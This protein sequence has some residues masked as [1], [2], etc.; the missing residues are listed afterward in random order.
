M[1]Q[2]IVPLPHND[3]RLFSNVSHAF[4]LVDL[5]KRLLDAAKNGDVEEV[6]NLMNNGAPFTT[7]WL[8]ISPLHFAA[9]NGHLSSCEALLRAGISRDARTKV[10][11]TPLHLAAQEGHADIVE[12][13][14][15]NGA[16]LDAKDMLRMTAL[17]WAAE[18]GHTPVV[19]MLMRFGADAHVQNKFEMTP[20]DI[21]ESKGHIDTRDA[22]LNTQYD[23]PFPVGRMAA[24]SSEIGN[25]NAYIL[26]DEE[27]LVPAAPP[28]GEVVVTAT[29]LDETSNEQ[30]VNSTNKLAPD[31]SLTEPPDPKNDLEYNA[32]RALI[33]GLGVGEVTNFAV[34]PELRRSPVHSG[35]VERMEPRR[36]SMEGFKDVMLVE[37]PDGD[38][39]YV[40]Q[41]ISASGTGSLCI[42][43][44]AGA[45]VN[46][47][48]LL[49]QVVEAMSEL[50]KGDGET[51]T[52]G[53]Q[54]GTTENENSTVIKK[55]PSVY[56]TFGSA[57]TNSSEKKVF[58]SITSACPTDTDTDEEDADLEGPN[59][60]PAQLAAH[61][62]SAEHPSTICVE[63]VGPNASIEDL[64]NWCLYNGIFIRCI[65]DEPDFIAEFLYKGESYT[66]TASYDS[67]LGTISFQRYR[68]GLE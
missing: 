1:N 27:T 24:A 44:S 39:L 19:Q 62:D 13:L 23:L 63:G 59:S 28:A 45:Q 32:A 46:D 9:M 25:T 37:T 5:G 60:L 35:A 22:M 40:R 47:P 26:T 18:R 4:S 17:H 38:I 66:L 58:S 67:E 31:P 30:D 55:E 16:D 11:R 7:D 2:Y 14:L 51:A 41:R 10:D 48:S 56:T 20:L 33:D 64:C 68:N 43:T 61:M 6:K 53:G 21:A 49:A 54:D 29:T 65:P 3:P 36:T 12:L 52:K 42:F 15:R 57:N 8:G 34:R 50:P